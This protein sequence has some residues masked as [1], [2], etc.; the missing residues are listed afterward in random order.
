MAETPR[1]LAAFQSSIR[2][3]LV[4][5]TVL[6][7]AIVVSLL[8]ALIARNATRQ[9]ENETSARLSQL[10]TQSA[11]AVSAFIDARAATVDLWAVDSLLLSVVRDP[12]LSAVFM[13]ALESYINRYADREPWIE[14][15]VVLTEDT[16]VFALDPKNAGP[17]V[18]AMGPDIAADPDAI[19]LVP[20]SRPPVLAISRPAIDRGQ[21][22]D[23]VLVILVVDVATMH[24][25]LLA[26]ARTGPNGFV[27]LMDA[28]GQPVGDTPIEMPRIGALGTSDRAIQNGEV[29][30][31][32]RPVPRTPLYVAGVATRSDIQ[33]PVRE[34]VTVSFLLG[35]GAIGLGLVGTIFFTGRVTAPIRRL[36]SDARQHTL[37]RFG[38]RAPQPL[39]VPTG[40]YGGGGYGA[41]EVG[42]LAA[43]FEL[44]GRT[45]DELTET[46]ALL[47]SRNRDLD[48]TRLRLRDN[49]DRL[50]RELDSARKLQVSMVP[51]AEAAVALA[52]GLD[53]AAL[54]E[55]AREVGGDFYD[56]LPIGDGAVC[57]I[58]GDVSDKGTPSALYM[59]RAISLLRF[60]IAQAA[61][62]STALP[63]PA[64]ILREVNAELCNHNST[65]MFVTLFLAMIDVRQGQ[66]IY[67]NGGHPSPIIQSAAGSVLLSKDNPDLPLGIRSQ[68]TYR[69]ATH[70]LT[71][72]ERVLLYTDGV[73]EA[74]ND[75]GAFYGTAR[76]MSEPLAAHSAATSAQAIHSIRQDVA[77]FS[78][79]SEQF[80]D[81]TMLAVGWR[82]M[83]Q[84]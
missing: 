28:T 68:A 35:L 72:G 25:Q 53:V 78:R 39:A 47:E 30:V 51:D 50:E 42:E 49:L 55:P 81:I 5:G 31:E 84:P 65:R 54:M 79:G 26:E 9:L 22:L 14:N 19:H 52:E 48:D 18:E 66:F 57:V 80:D 2:M 59:A 46:N 32:I 12:G 33:A 60:A 38:Q 15:V 17:V 37:L 44:L 58:I 61:K 7:L 34:L 40:Q 70:Q 76:L 27:A 63:D 67:A 71:P 16:V 36:T 43:V 29:L 10:A 56:F 64:A 41:D 11:R 24:D 21:P 83:G 6:I 20:G 75:Q 45:T 4:I 13:P 73:S 74:E 82:P 3:Q 1:G 62:Q 8:T 69:T 23:G 77:E